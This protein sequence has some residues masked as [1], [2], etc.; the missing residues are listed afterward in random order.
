[1]RAAM[2]VE[3]A[4]PA[5]YEVRVLEEL[6]AAGGAREFARGGRVVDGGVLIEVVADQGK[7]TGLVANAP[8][9]VAAA[10]TG[11][12][13]T[14]SPSVVCVV[15]RGEAY[16]I[17]VHKPERW[18]A[19]EESPVVAVRSATADGLLVLANPRRVM[20]VGQNGMAWRTP[21]LAIDGIELG[22]PADGVLP[23]VS[24]PRDYAEEFVVDLRTGRHEGG[25]SFH[26]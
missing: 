7:W 4:F 23:G 24:D 21:R 18:W 1:M 25:F 12:Y 19:L 5:A 14:P 26:D 15:A 10:Q 17:E 11:V 3:L 2:T 20:A 22:E 6:P 9:S 16:F 8:A 13:S